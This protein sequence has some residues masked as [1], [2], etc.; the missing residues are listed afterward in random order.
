MKHSDRITAMVNRQDFDFSCRFLSK[1][2]FQ[3]MNKSSTQASFSF[4]LSV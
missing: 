2:I 1:E 4:C 3:Q